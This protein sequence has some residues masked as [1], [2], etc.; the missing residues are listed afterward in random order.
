[1]ANKNAVDADGFM[2]FSTIT[3]IG[4]ATFSGFAMPLNLKNKKL[5]LYYEA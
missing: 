2:T 3:D 1:M 5:N 4:N